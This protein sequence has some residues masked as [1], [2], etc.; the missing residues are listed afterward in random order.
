[1]KEK[2]KKEKKVRDESETEKLRD[3]SRRDVVAQ[4]MTP[5]PM[6]TRE[7]PNTHAA[8]NCHIPK[9]ETHLAAATKTHL[10]TQEPT[11][12]LLKRR[13]EKKYQH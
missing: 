3:P 4:A 5:L 2:R 10:A 1:M 11:T 8:I 12:Q 6:P 13:F 9:P 7:R